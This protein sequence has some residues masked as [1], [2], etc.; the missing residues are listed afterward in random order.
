MQN[1][2]QAGAGQDQEPDRRLRKRVK[3]SAPVFFAGKMLRVAV[4][5][6]GQAFV[7]CK[8]QRVTEPAQ[9]LAGQKPLAIF[10]AVAA[11]AARR[12]SVPFPQVAMALGPC[13]EARYGR[14]RPVSW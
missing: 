7:L 14:E 8:P 1:L 3:L 5:F 10:L 13:V 2:P 11:N 4:R 9:F 12:V 6:P